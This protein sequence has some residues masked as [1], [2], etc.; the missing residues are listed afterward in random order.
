MLSAEMAPIF[1]LTNWRNI[2]FVFSNTFALRILIA[3]GSV[4]EFELS[5]SKST[6]YFKIKHIKNDNSILKTKNKICS[7]TCALSRFLV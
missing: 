1:D 3:L 7:Y 4:C 2:L 6:V 5:I